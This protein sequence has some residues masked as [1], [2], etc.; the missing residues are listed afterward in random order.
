MKNKPCYQFPW[1]KQ[2][3]YAF[4]GGGGEVMTHCE[5]T[6]GLVFNPFGFSSAPPSPTAYRGK[7]ERNDG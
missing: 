1:S 3:S 5:G 4:G 6:G 2:K 7:K